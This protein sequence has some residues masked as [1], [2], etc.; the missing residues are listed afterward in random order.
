MKNI[1]AKFSSERVYAFGLGLGV[2]Y[3]L[4]VALIP[5]SGLAVER[6]DRPDHDAVRDEVNEQICTEYDLSRCDGGQEGGDGGDSGDGGSGGGGGDGGSGG[7]GGSA[8]DAITFV[9]RTPEGVAYETSYTLPSNETTVVR[10]TDGMHRIAV[11]AKSALASLV[12]IDELSRAFAI[13]DLA[14]FPSFS[15]FYLHC[16]E[17]R[18]E[19]DLCGSWQYSVNG[20]YP[21]VGLDDQL[22]EGGD[23]FHLYFG[24]MRMVEAPETVTSG[25]SFVA[26]AKRYDV[27]TGGYVPAGGLTIG[28]TRS[29]PDDPW[30]PVVV[31]TAQTDVDGKATFVAPAAGMYELGIKEDGY[32]PSTPLTVV[33]AGSTAGGTGGGGGGTLLRGG[34]ADVF[35]V[36]AA[37][38]FLVTQQEA[39]G[40][41][42]AP[43][44]TDWAAIAFAAAGTNT[45]EVREHL[46]KETASVTSLTDHERRAMALMALGVD[47]Y[48]GT[49]IDH[50]AAIRAEFKDGQFGDPKRVNDDLFALIVL[51]RVG[52][53]V[54]DV[55]VDG[56]ITSVLK[57]QTAD[58]AWD[59]SADLTAAAIQALVP[60]RAAS[61]VE[62][63]L[64]K[65]ETYLRKVQK[66]DGGFGDAFA[67]AWVLQA[68]D[69]L[70]DS[71]KDWMVGGNTPLTYLARA[72]QTDGGV[73][74]A[75]E[76][77]STRVWV[78]AYAIP[79]ALGMSW[80][81]VLHVFSAREL[82]LAEARSG[83]RT[84]STTNTS[85]VTP[86]FGPGSSSSTDAV[87]TFESWSSATTSASSTSESAVATKT[88][89]PDQAAAAAAAG[90]LSDTLRLLALGFLAVLVGYAVFRFRVAK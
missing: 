15:S 46:K 47:P 48:S 67:T 23:T 57:A 69:V 33:A 68:I 81:E 62:G 66:S 74:A 88:D 50:V 84:S 51:E 79:A 83:A 87:Y 78:T 10:S 53:R 72:Q 45:Q 54:G 7:G 85:D 43:I 24:A 76:A 2:L 21:S 38:R 82:A 9:L 4:L 90:G 44:Y 3:G 28:I 37:L 16:L 17:V 36:D 30:A 41:F 89:S 55:Q 52:Y 73:L 63:A 1:V 56:A 86:S 60:Y 22:L 49:S 42:G 59:A 29:N 34:S 75:T 18:G 31:A 26:L 6:P 12:T 77:T 70:G 58:G 5:L 61:G 20:S 64:L 71:P 25:S 40:T 14:Y 65:A 13:T 35:D 39:N 80:R 32:Y 19:G 8:Q 11:P 27:T